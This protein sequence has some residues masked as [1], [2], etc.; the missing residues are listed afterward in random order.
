MFGLF[1]TVD[2]ETYQLPPL[3]LEAFDVRTRQQVETIAGSIVPSNLQTAITAADL[4]GKVAAAVSSADI[5]GQVSAA[6]TEQDIPALVG[7]AVTAA[8]IPG[9]VSAELALQSGKVI[10][11]TGSPLGVLNSPVGTLYVDTA[12][13]NGARLWLKNGASAAG[14]VVVSGDTGWRELP[15][16]VGWSGR[17]LGR[18]IGNTVELQAAVNP[19]PEQRPNPTGV[20]EIPEIF[21]RG[22][23]Q[24]WR[25]LRHFNTGT[26]GYADAQDRGSSYAIGGL[27]AIGAITFT[28]THLAVGPWPTALPGTP[29]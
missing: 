25:G 6:V 20:L 26:G 19:P 14:W 9:Q 3:I 28:Q 2:P 8:D 10:Q 18:R 29:T 16:P 11:G 4:P 12:Q 7:S 23:D 27:P 15:L 5:P 13:T 24:S 1:V 22:G 17:F 21:R